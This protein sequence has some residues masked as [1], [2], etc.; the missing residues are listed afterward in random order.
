MKFGKTIKCQHYNDGFEGLTKTNNETI[1]AKEYQLHQNSE[2]GD[3]RM[4]TITAYVMAAIILGLVLLLTFLIFLI[5]V[6][7]LK[8]SLGQFISR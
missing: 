5:K 1:T 4:I 3:S 6:F 7:L 2:Q 8:V